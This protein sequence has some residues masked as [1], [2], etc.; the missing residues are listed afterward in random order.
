MR[1]LRFVVNFPFPGPK[2]RQA[3]WA[4]VLPPQTP[5]VTDEILAEAAR[6]VERGTLEKLDFERLAKEKLDF[7][8]L[9]R[10]N[11]TG[12]SIHNVGLSAAFLAAQ[13]G[14]PVTMSL[15]L[16][17][18]RSEFRKLGRPFNET[19]FRQPILSNP[20]PVTSKEAI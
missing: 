19:D 6:N 8:Q 15:V 20:Q 11:L 3:I 2:E 14:T 17:A 16:A 4:K 13:A 7:T 10:L 12:G 9:A 18:A 5:V 1:R